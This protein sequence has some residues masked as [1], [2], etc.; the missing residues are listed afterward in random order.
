MLVYGDIVRT[1]TAAEALA[2]V[3]ADLE[4]AAGADGLERHALLVAAL[5][6]LGE[7]A[8]AVADGEFEDRGQDAPSPAQATLAEALVTIARAVQRS[9][10]GGGGEPVRL[11]PPA[12]PDR[13]LSLRQPEGYA[14]YALYP[15]TYLEAARGLPPGADWRVVGVR[16]IG[17][18]L[19][20]V[21]AA[22]LQAPPPITVRPVGH[23]FDRRLSLT[24]ELLAR[25]SPEARVAVVDEG[26]GLSGS[27]FGAV[28][29]TLEAQ[30]VP[31]ARIHVFPS[32][33]GDLGPQAPQERRARW[34]RANRHAVGFDDV[35]L[36]RLRGWAADLLG[37]AAAPLEDISGGAWRRGP[38]AGWPPAN[39]FQERRKFLHHSAGGVWLLKFAGL[40]RI[41]ERKLARA[42][43]LHAA[44]FAPEPAGLLHGFLAERWTPHAAPPEGEPPLTEYLS[45]RSRFEAPPEAGA[46]AEALLRMAQVNTAEA[47]GAAAAEPLHRFEGPL[48]AL[49]ARIRR[50][51]TDNRLH[52]WEWIAAPTGGWLKT[53]GLDHHAAHDL[54]GSQ[55]IAWDVAGAEAEFDL[56]ADAVERLRRQVGA[57]A[58]LL[59]FYRP[60]Y[61]AFQLGAYAMAA[62]AH[63]GWPEEAARLETRRRQYQD[64]L[65]RLLVDG[66][67]P[68][69]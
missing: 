29:D 51:E 20:A 4:R 69:V 52:A 5:I 39:T 48:P 47:L 11:E 16:S 59:A 35:I 18:S 64:R 43:T 15:E 53:D 7:L 55:D 66:L 14:F 10:H 42:R 22:A 9:W 54:V 45:L 28:L 56:D 32:H 31:P 2:E 21:V 30:G 46:S 40:G 37:G 33:G 65:A 13:P 67:G 3:G 6:G 58:A 60:C 63:A 23:P 49:Q 34:A 41:G 8:Q 38:E 26:P 62:D 61:L 36:P 19:A 50:V 17:T 57:D 24:Q 25:L 27:S 44:G 1:R 12:I 68:G